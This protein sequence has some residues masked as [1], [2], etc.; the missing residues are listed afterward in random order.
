MKHGFTLRRLV[1]T[2][3]GV[4]DAEVGFKCGL[5][6]IA[7]PSDTGKTYIAQCINFVMGSGKAPKSIPE[8]KKYR[9]IVLEIEARAESRS[10]RLE[11]GLAGGDIRLSTPGGPDTALL[12]KH[13]ADNENTISNF[14]L[15]LSGFQGKKVQIDQQGKTRP[16]SFR[17]IA[18]L[19]LIDEESVIS[20]RSPI[21]GGQ[22]AARQAEQSVFRLLLTGVDASSVIAKEDPRI[23]QGRQAGK[24][25]AF[26]VLLQR[27]RDQLRELN[28]IGGIAEFKDEFERLEAEVGVASSELDG[29]QKS[30]AGVEEQRRNA[31]T[32]LRQVESQIDVLLQLQKRFELLGEQ[33]SSD[34][35]RL[36]AI[37][38]A[39]FSL[40]QM[41]EERCP[42]CGALPEHHERQHQ[43]EQF[44]PVD[45]AQACVAEVVKTKQL[46]GDLQTTLVSSAEQAKALGTQRH[47]LQARLEAIDKSL[48]ELLLPR[49]QKAV[50]KLRD[51]QTRRDACRR[52]LELLKQE[53][54]LEDHLAKARIPIK[55][56]P[57]VNPWA[58]VKKGE[59][60]LFSSEVET[61]LRAWRFPGLQRVTFS[62][63][64]FDI[65]ISGRS[66]GS[67]G[68]G[69][70]ALTRA[71]FNL[72][73]LR[74]CVRE[75]KP[76]PGLVLI[77][78][79]LVVYREPDK[80]EQAFPQE[81]KDAFYR[82]LAKDFHDAQV[83]ILEN[84]PPPTD[85]NASAN[86]IS[87][88]GNNRGRKGFIQV[89]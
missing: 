33:Y 2:G 34:L 67:H 82:S 60:D 16:L 30:A 19:I 55:K 5:N 77:D 49:V 53:W 9:S 85:I 48:K 23:A 45:I 27:A 11:R 21:Y 68:K 86:V 56:E 13:Q 36:A 31:W 42:V 54:D 20:E 10:Y 28:V 72:A 41:R 17:D 74:L 83:I 37:S 69:V 89:G 58:A 14:L 81:V 75:G 24:V 35:R 3:S 84:D 71:A 1:L 38:E 8:A 44:T 40:D 62:E 64:G 61:L 50:Q 46:L 79:P 43:K 87:F 65:V 26:T 12:G 70:R 63:K 15:K 51:S 66:R 7:G 39:G 29:E 25:E 32:A 18:M 78:S 73:L 80:E 22:Y 88:T 59:T 57:A 6:V 76:F 52:K 47:S 4:Q